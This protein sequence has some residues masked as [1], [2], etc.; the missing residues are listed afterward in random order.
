MKIGIPKGLLYYKYG[1]FMKTFFKKLGAEII[2]SPDTNRK[3]LNEGAKY[4]VDEA[5]LPIKVFHGHVSYLKDKC[6]AIF[7]PR[8]MSIREKEYICPKFCGLTEMI[9]NS[10]PGLP[11]LLG[12]PIYFTPNEKLVKWALNTGKY[13]TNDKQKIKSALENAWLKQNGTT[14]TIKQPKLKYKVA[15]LG[16]PY[17]VYDPFLNMDLV[18]KLN[19]LNVEI[20]TEDAVDDKSIDF[21]VN[22]LFKKPF[23][24][25]A[26]NTYGAAVNLAKQKKI[27]GMVYVSSFACGIDSVLIELIEHETPN[28]PFIVLKIDEH[29]GEAGFNTRIEAF[30]DMLGRRLNFAYNNT[31][32]G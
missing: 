23:W 11:F 6:D 24:S 5:C 12:E 29:T 21:E 27:D 19:Q 14:I 20:I 30:A 10:I 2:V 31:A 4:C 13:L 18:K 8:I 16:H 3:I 15:L 9:A 25:F 1:V 22:K 32:Y 28:I 7:I 17:N 26:R